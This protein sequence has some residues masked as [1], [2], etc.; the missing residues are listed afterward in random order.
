MFEIPPRFS[1]HSA[2]KIGLNRGGRRGTQRPEDRRRFIL[3]VIDLLCPGMC[4]QLGLLSEPL[5]Q[6]TAVV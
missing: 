1:A 4:R 3:I 2:V 5:L 6:L